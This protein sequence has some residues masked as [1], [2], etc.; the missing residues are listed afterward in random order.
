MLVNR[1]PHCDCSRCTTDTPS[2]A[3]SF[4]PPKLETKC[5]WVSPLYQPSLAG[6]NS[7]LTRS[8]SSR[9]SSPTGTIASSGW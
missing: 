1:L 7:R 9:V 4:S 3:A 2:A 8:V 6:S 5:T